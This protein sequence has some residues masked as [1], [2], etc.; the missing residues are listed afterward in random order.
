[1]FYSNWIKNRKLGQ[2]DI[3][4]SFNVI[5]LLFLLHQ[6]SVKEKQLMKGDND[7]TAEL[8]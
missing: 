6:S 1:M 2:F 5:I 4:A 7:V 3:V 8:H